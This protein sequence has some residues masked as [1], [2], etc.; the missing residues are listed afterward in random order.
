MRLIEGGNPRPGL[1]SK[2]LRLNKSALK[3]K[4]F[5]LS[6]LSRQR[7]KGLDFIN[8]YEVFSMFQYRKNTGNATWRNE[9]AKQ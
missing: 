4:L 2:E 9:G 7:K 3:D 8:C 5:H 6:V 1:R